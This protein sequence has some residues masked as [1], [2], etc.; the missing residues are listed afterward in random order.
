M[1]ATAKERKIIRISPKRQI[2]IPQK[3]FEQLGFGKEAECFVRERELVIRPLRLY[4]SA[5]GGE[6]AEEILADLIKQGYS[7]EE[8]LAQFKKMQRQIRPA[9]ER[10]LDE[11]EALA[12][13]EYHGS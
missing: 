12:N 10:M 3:Q 6:F 11:A 2:T 1:E 4:D 13:S 8:L 7:G 9:V 5:L